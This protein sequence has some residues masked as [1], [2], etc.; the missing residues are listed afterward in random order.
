MG[1]LNMKEP[2]SISMAQTHA[3]LQM[4]NLYDPHIQQN[5]EYYN[6]DIDKFL[7]RADLEHYE[8]D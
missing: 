7:G 6:M 4:G 8:F 1:S 2:G 3:I 5:L